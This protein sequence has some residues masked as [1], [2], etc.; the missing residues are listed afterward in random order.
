M[1]GSELHDR[2]Q[3]IE[4]KRYIFQRDSHRWIVFILHFKSC[5]TNRID[6]LFIV[7]GIDYGHIHFNANNIICTSNKWHRMHRCHNLSY[8]YRITSTGQFPQNVL[9]FHMYYLS[10]DGTIQ[11]IESLVRMRIFFDQIKWTNNIYIKSSC[12]VK[13]VKSVKQGKIC[14]SV[15]G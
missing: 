8:Q 7:H 5:L 1:N 15:E 2:I 13:S 3:N 6:N 12:K 9:L 4:R 14:M 10:G 11:T